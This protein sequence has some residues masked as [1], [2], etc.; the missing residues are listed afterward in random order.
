MSFNSNSNSSSEYTDSENEDDSMIDWSL[1]IF[2]DRYIIIK[3]L[4]KGSYVRFGYLM[5]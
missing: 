3:K 5:I 2:N 1:N 4:G